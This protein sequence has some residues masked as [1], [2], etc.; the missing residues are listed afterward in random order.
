MARF[1]N[2]SPR[3]VEDTSYS[4]GAACTN[5]RQDS[6]PCILRT[7]AW[8]HVAALLLACFLVVLI[9]NGAGL[10]DIEPDAEKNGPCQPVDACPCGR[11]NVAPMSSRRGF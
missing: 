10:P 3:S 5:S 1:E 11:V 4:G 8:T 6:T 2:E 9:Q 7:V